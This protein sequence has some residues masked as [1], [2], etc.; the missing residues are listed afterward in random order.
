MARAPNEDDD[1]E[2]PLPLIRLKVEYTAPEGGKFDCENPQRFSNRFI[3]RVANTNDVVYFWRKKTAASRMSH[4]DLPTL[5]SSP[6]VSFFSFFFVNK[7]KS[8]ADFIPQE[9]AK[10]TQSIFQNPQS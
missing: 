10:M 8:H 5:L 2:P 1:V 4:L 3:G 9:T 6:F 7:F